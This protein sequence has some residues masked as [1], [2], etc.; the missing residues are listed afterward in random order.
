MNKDIKPINY[1]L[2]F[3]PN[4]KTFKFLG[5]EKIKFKVLKP[6]NKI[7]LNAA[8][9]KIK[10]CHLILQNK[11]IKPKKI[12][13]DE[14]KETVTM[15]CSHKIAGD[16]ELFLDF[17]GILNDKLAGFY[18]S[19]YE[20][21]GRKKYLATTQFEAADARR[22]FPCWDEPEQ[23]ATFDVTMIVDKNLTA[24]SNMPA[25]KQKIVKGKKI[26]QFARTPIMSTYLLYLGVGEFEYIQD[27][28]GKILIRVITTPGKKTQGKLALNFAKQFLNFFQNYFRIPYP[29]P[30]LDLIALPDFASGAM[31][32]WGAI[33][34]RE[35]VLLFDPKVSATVTKQSIA[36]VL[37]HEL[38]H[39]WFGNL[40]TMKWWNDLWLN[41]SFATFMAY[42]AVNHYYPQW[43]IW[44]QFLNSETVEAMELD[45]LKSSHPIDV[46]VNTP[47]EIREIF[48]EISYE[49]GGS[50]LRM[51][52]NY[53]GEENFRRGLTK[54]LSEHKYGNATT[55][56]LWMSLA[57]VSKKPVK[58][59]M[60]TW[61]KQQGYPIVE[62]NIADLKLILSQKRFLLE[63]KPDKTKWLIP[64]L[65]KIG[66]E[67]IISELMKE[68]A[69]TI[70]TGQG[71][72]WLKINLNQT[73]F[74]RVK[75]TKEVLEKLKFVVLN[76]KLGNLDRFGIQNDLFFLALSG[77]VSVNDYLNFVKSF[78]NEDDYLVLKDIS[79]N[80]SF[81]YFMT[82]GEKIWERIKGFNKI[83]F[84]RIFN[85]LGWK[86]R[87]GEKHTDPILRSYAIST[88]GRMDDEKI[89]K[90][91]NEKFFEFLKNPNSLHP[92]LRGTVYSLVAWKGNEE[93]YEQLIQLYRKSKIQE[94]KRRF[95]AAL[96]NFKEQKI[97]NQTLKF[98][99]SKEVRSQDLF[100]PIA[101]ISGNPYGKDIIWPWIKSNWEELRNRYTGGSAQLLT[102]I[103]ESLGVLSDMKK[104]KEIKN[105]FRKKSTEGIEMSLAQ[106]L[107]R[108]RIHSRFLE[109]LRQQ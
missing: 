17:E 16:A 30:K 21:K 11:S 47:A 62:A 84:K 96:A 7:V 36:E 54:H 29:L 105:F 85:R 13:L 101:R 75:Y 103:V 41:E 51:L 37:S 15:E 102:R 20:V 59:M 56:N 77:D 5:K 14:K 43:D 23:K 72:E 50:I 6:T 67:K 73:G 26:V 22:A 81:L 107:E 32:N 60:N 12:T 24:I 2:T 40:V 1:E 90:A 87:E 61:V 10:H 45:A 63:N 52:E 9:L 42:K 78:S 38:V 83:F 99:L 79:D 86:P 71:L 27:K 104:G 53:L 19:E 70:K 100:I 35:V 65:G 80:L 88:L 49:K 31:E 97:L 55:E 46:K 109:K 18:R 4:L 8:D 48:D 64:V 28:L 58:E 94:E 91:A 82:Y 33:T 98:S 68:K 66:E 89:L 93:T 76:K 74:Y 25:I 39:Q 3:E 69:K 108:I 95:L 34:F 106:T 44:S 57:K 92:D